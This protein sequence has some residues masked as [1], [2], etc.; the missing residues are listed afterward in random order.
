MS[1]YNLNDLIE[2]NKEIEALAVSF[3]LDCYE[4][5][6]ELCSYEDML[7]SEAYLG[8]PTRYPHWSFGKAYERKKTFYRYNLTGLPYEMVINSNPCL[9]YL[10]KDNTLLLQVLTM[11]H[12]YGHNDFF[13]NNRYFR[14]GT[15]ADSAV[16]M[17]NS[18]ARRIRM[19]CAD[20]SIG[21]HRVEKVLDAAHAL[22]FQTRRVV[23]EKQE[24]RE[25]IK[26]RLLDRHGTGKSEYPLLQSN[27]QKKEINLDALVLQPE[28][29]LLLFLGRHG[30]LSDW[31][32][33]VVEMVREESLYFLPQVETKIMNEGWASFWH[34]KMLNEM[35]LPQELHIEFL[36]RHN[37]VVCAHEG[38]LNP[39]HLGYKIFEKLASRSDG[40]EF[41]FRVREQERDASFILRYL[42]EELCREMHLFEYFRSGREYVISEVPDEQGWKKVRLTLANQVGLNAI[43]N[44]RV[45]DVSDHNDIL[46]LEHESDGRDLQLEYAIRTL[47]HVASLWGRK[48]V[49]TTCVRGAR[50]VL[51][52]SKDQI[53]YN[54]GNF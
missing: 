18:H 35:N 40:A 45:Q 12:V 16:E 22:R 4:Q 33:D 17:F 36:K 24:T 37:Q 41:I 51:E 28:D 26:Q 32:R 3:G 52:S 1:N 39:Y 20:P 7:A 38:S 5:E 43:P 50:Q 42:D 29:D 10:M 13:K 11:A 31:E 34:F 27:N 21:H 2:Y 19:Y 48:V 49:L 9:A 47:R 30:K 46:Y 44:I 25:E 23:G 8:M 6:F 54:G 15:R 53:I 14:I